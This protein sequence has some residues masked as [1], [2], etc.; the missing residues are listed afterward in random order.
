MRCFFHLHVFDFVFYIIVGHTLTHRAI[1]YQFLQ[2]SVQKVQY[3]LNQQFWLN[4]FTDF[5]W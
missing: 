4:G 1:I 5:W 2:I 3:K